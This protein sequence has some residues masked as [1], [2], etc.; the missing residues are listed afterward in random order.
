MDRGFDDCHCPVTDRRRNGRYDIPGRRIYQLYK[1]NSGTVLSFLRLIFP[2]FQ[3]KWQF[4]RSGN[5]TLDNPLPTIY[6][7]VAK[8]SGEKGTHAYEYVQLFRTRIENTVD[9]QLVIEVKFD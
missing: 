3:K 7:I 8:F 2:Y 4:P 1:I 9:D 6:K 5:I